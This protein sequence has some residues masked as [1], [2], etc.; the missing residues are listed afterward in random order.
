MENKQYHNALPVNYKLHWYVI[1]EVL[2]RGG[3]G[4]TYLAID[5][6]LDRKVA[7]KEFLPS[8]LCYRD[9]TDS[10]NPMQTDSKFQ[11]DWGLERFLSEAKTLAK[12][13]HPN[14]VRVIAVFEENKTGYMVMNY[15]EGDELQELLSREKTLDEDFL[16]LILFPLLDGLEKIH[17]AGFIHRDI[18]PQNIMLRPNGTP[19]LID[20]GSARQALGGKTSTLTSLVSP[21]YAPFEQYYS[22][23]D[24]QGPWTDIYA[25]AATL[26]RCVSGKLP[27]S[28]VDRSEGI[29]HG[30]GDYFV[31]A[32]EIGKGRYSEEFLKA[33]DR[34]LCFK[35]EE[36][37]QT[38]A[39]WRKDFAGLEDI[40]SDNF[41]DDEDY[42]DET[43]TIQAIENKKPV[44][45]KHDIGVK[46][47]KK[48]NV[49][50]YIT[51]TLLF[52]AVIFLLISN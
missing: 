25:L 49:P 48:R 47:D 32:V 31:S 27:L 8:E 4:I 19:I 26:Y 17:N 41:I 37:P 21:G 52:V 2:G 24:K 45:K 39:E 10:V 51:G 50:A 36:R 5:T 6:N 20:F 35:P 28:A 29:V 30:T 43:P 7:I 12:F 22:K 13:E 9:N 15:E 23:G 11:Y 3:F 18:K 33:I 16:L 46:P 14:I 42:D 40:D 34:G 38:I 44:E 1:K